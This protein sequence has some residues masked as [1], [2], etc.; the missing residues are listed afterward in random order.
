MKYDVD[1]PIYVMVDEESRD[2]LVAAEDIYGFFINPGEQSTEVAFLGVH[3]INRSRRRAED[4]VLDITNCR[5]EKIGEYF[6]G[7]VGGRDIATDA[8]GSSDSRV[9]Y[10]L[11]GNRCEHP[12][13]RRIW[14]RWASRVALN[15]DEWVQ[16]PAGHQ[17]AWLHVVQNCWFTSNRRAARY[18]VH[19]VAHLDGTHIFTKAGFFCALGEA[20][21]GPGGYFGSNLD[22]LEDCISSSY[23][24]GPIT[25]I[26][27]RNFESSKKSLDD[28]FLNSIM[29]MM[30]EFGIEVVH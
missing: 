30:R 22:A 6:I 27:W 28:V 15:K 19:D 4:A 8:T 5:G 2:V 18:G 3:E 7:R 23:G 9:S 20:V 17:E 10:R 24:E 11:F 25:K 14:R 1:F 13:A 29:G 12:S 26:V 16:L 21:N